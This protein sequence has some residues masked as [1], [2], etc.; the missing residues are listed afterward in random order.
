MAK[1]TSHRELRILEEQRKPWNIKSS[2][3]HQIFTQ[4]SRQVTDRKKNT[5]HPTKTSF[6]V[7][8]CVCAC[9]QAC[10]RVC[11]FPL[12]PGGKKDTIFNYRTEMNRL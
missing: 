9:T 7:C 8:V 12:P 10:A 4:C 2:L 6:N 3:S 1:Y 5:E 11:F